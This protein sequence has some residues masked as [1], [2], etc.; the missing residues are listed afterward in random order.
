MVEVPQPMVRAAEEVDAGDDD[1]MIVD[2][3]HAH[4]C[5]RDGNTGSRDCRANDAIASAACESP[6]DAEKRK[7]R[8]GEKEVRGGRRE[9]SSSSTGVGS[10]E[11]RLEEGGE[12][13][14]GC[15]TECNSCGHPPVAEQAVRDL[16]SPT[17]Q[18]NARTDEQ[19]D[20]DAVFDERE[21]C[22]EVVPSISGSHADLVQMPD[23]EEN[24]CAICLEEFTDDDPAKTTYCGY[25]CTNLLSCVLCVCVMQWGTEGEGTVR[26]LP[27]S[28]WPPRRAD[29]HVTRLLLSMHRTHVH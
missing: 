24:V 23:V 3:S 12:G 18:T 1:E 4:G 14:S 26:G 22:P 11:E 25:V 16:T 10:V 19:A 13:D 29:A 8:K 7:K 27:P 9:E 6:T 20:D 17:T 2:E 15:G 28:S 5:D 21:V